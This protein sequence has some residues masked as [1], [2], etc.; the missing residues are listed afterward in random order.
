MSTQECLVYSLVHKTMDDVI[1]F[2]VSTNS[3]YSVLT[4]MENS[5]LDYVLIHPKQRSGLPIG[6]NGE[7]EE[8]DECESDRASARP[9]YRRLLADGYLPMR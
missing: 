2:L 5:E 9:I 7:W 3:G 6:P 1:E 4:G 8:C